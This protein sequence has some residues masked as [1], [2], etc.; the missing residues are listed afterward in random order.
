M[1]EPGRDPMLGEPPAK[2]RDIDPIVPTNHPRNLPAT[3][4]LPHCS[5]KPEESHVAIPREANLPIDTETKRVVARV[6]TAV[7]AVA[8]VDADGDQLRK[9][10]GFVVEFDEASMIGTV[11]SS[12][13]V[14]KRDSFFPN[15]EKIK[16]YVFDGA[17]Y[18]ATI[19]ACDY[20]WNLLVLSVSFNKVVKTMKLVELRENRNSRNPHLERCSLLPHS[21]CE[22]LYPGDTIIGLGRWAEEPFG[23]QANC[24]L[25]ST[26][27]WTAFHQLCQEMQ[28][29]AFL[30]TYTAIGGPAINRNGRVTGML[31]QSRTCT[32]FLPSNIILRWWEHFKNTGK[33]CHPTIRVFGVN[34]HNAPSSPWVKVPTTLHE[35]LDGL[36]VELP[37]RAALSV[38]L[39]QKDLI[40]QCN[41]KHVATSLQLFEILVGNIGKMVELTVIKAEDGTTHSINLPVEETVEEKFYSWPISSYHGGFF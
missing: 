29:A 41:G 17:S 38:G 22:N 16:V 12:A 6:S 4:E 33:Y 18:D 8:S 9:A 37:L 23:L 2:R 20:H 1:A 13:T 30:N 40:I 28:K 25:Y 5:C 7:V 15:F 32:P 35:G 21:A 24:G 36:L 19:I 31:F 10:S 26:E 39:H 34:L 27:R 3:L 14:A 11:F